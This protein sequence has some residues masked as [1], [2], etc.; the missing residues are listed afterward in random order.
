MEVQDVDSWPPCWGL[1]LVKTLPNL[2]MRE[3]SAYYM[4][5]A[6]ALFRAQSLHPLAA[7]ADF[8]GREFVLGYRLRPIMPDAPA[9]WPA[10]RSPSTST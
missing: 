6:L 5:R 3:P 8:R 2:L 1:L 7:P 10:R 4:R 9:A